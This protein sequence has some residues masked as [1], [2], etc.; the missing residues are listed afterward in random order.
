MI[1]ECQ[2]RYNKEHIKR[3]PL[4]MQIEEYE[5]IKHL[6]DAEGIGVNTFIKKLIRESIGHEPN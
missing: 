5:E 3:I 4:D 2:K 6:A 1:R